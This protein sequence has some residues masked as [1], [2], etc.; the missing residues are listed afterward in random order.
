MIPAPRT[1]PSLLRL[2]LWIALLAGAMAQPAQA[3]VKNGAGF[4]AQDGAFP[5]AVAIVP[6]GQPAYTGHFCGGT[7]VS[8]TRVVTAAH[9]ID[10]AGEYQA[11]P[12][13]IEVVVGQTS[14][15]AGVAVSSW[16]VASD[17]TGF[18]QGQ[19]L[20]V[21]AISLHP[22]ANVE[23]Y[24]DDVA[25]LTLASPVTVTSA[26]VAP[27][28]PGGATTVDAGSES[29]ADAWGAG[30]RTWVL[31]WGLTSESAFR[32]PNV[33]NYAGMGTVAAPGLPRLSD[34]TCGDPTRLGSAYRAQ[35]MLCAG[36][37][38]GS[39]Q[40]PDACQGDSGGPLLK[41]TKPI[42]GDMA[43][44]LAAQKDPSYWRLVGVTSWGEGCARPQYPGV[45]ARVGAQ[46]IYDYILSADPPSMPAVPDLATAGPRLS[47]VYKVGSSVTCDVGTWT[48][49]T[50][51][52]FSVWRDLNGNGVRDANSALTEPYVPVTAS[53]DGT[54][55][56]YAA[57]PSDVTRSTATAALGCRVTA[58]GPGGYAAYNA[59]S[60]TPAQVASDPQPGATA[61]VTPTPT[62]PA[63]AAASD[64]VAPVISKSSLVCSTKACRVALVVVDRS[65]SPNVSGISTVAF[66]LVLHRKTTCAITSGRNKG[67]RKPCTKSVTKA[68]RAKQ[69]GDQYVLQ[70][71][72][73]RKADKPKL[74]AIATDKSGN[75]TRYSVTLK[76]RSGR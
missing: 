35:D 5:F 13:A 39:T 7:L 25:L 54:S 66:S 58:H 63:V 69:S 48:G 70:L 26:F 34:A 24:Y 31:G 17:V 72:S 60:F 23:K 29:T 32:Q 1:N 2:V 10:P 38:T 22:N 62:P 6:A 44:L 61:P 73:L 53:P 18:T 33:L 67:R 19:R 56:S 71:T 42:A 40:T 46:E 37:Q 30:L 14:L 50:R 52:E 57:A 20:G 21:A 28:T 64:T 75:R 15:C 27:V 55:A 12:S 59:P 49:A 11:T 43:S 3:V 4:S 76:L 8:A 36:S 41:Q 68:V 45:Y 16:C 51:Y 74:Q 65:G 47:G 9:C